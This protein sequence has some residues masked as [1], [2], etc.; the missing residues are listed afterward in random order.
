MIS[1]IPLINNDYLLTF[2]YIIIII[3]SL[4][5]KYE[6]KDFLFLIFGIFIMIISEAFF[7]STGVETFNR[8]TLFNLMPLWLP[9]LWGYTFVVM[10]RIINILNS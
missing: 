5:I 4:L 1:L 7:I 8:Q 2:I 3:L 9:F 10:K 6:V